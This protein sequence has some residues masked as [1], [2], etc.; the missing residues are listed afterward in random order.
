MSEYEYVS[1]EYNSY[2]ITSPHENKKKLVKKLWNG[3][4]NNMMVLF[5]RRLSKR[6]IISEVNNA[7]SLFSFKQT[8][9]PSLLFTLS[10]T[11]SYLYIN[12]TS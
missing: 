6:C 9:K 12:H 4:R 5:L 1:S 3:S 11:L 2:L 7:Y 8:I 10:I